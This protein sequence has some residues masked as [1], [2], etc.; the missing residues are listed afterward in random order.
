MLLKNLLIKN[1]SYRTFYQEGIPIETL[2][3]IMENT[4][5]CPSARNSQT[6]RYFIINSETFI[7]KVFPLTKW[8]GAIPWNPSIEES[9]VAYILISSKSKSPLPDLTLGIDI[10]IVAQTILLSATELGLGGCLLGAFD[11]KSLEKLLELPENEYSHHLLV[12][13]GHPKDKSTIVKA[14]SNNLSYF[15]DIKNYENFV[16]KLDLKELILGIY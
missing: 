14:E 10:G 3:D 12:A 6:L 7:N 13:L 2:L 1:R 8:A 5:L 4:R 16:P 15:R 9:P 11:K